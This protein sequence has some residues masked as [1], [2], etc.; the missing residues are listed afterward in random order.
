MNFKVGDEFLIV[1]PKGEKRYGL[2]GFVNTI[3]TITRIHQDTKRVYFMN[4]NWEWS[5]RVEHA[6]KPTKLHRAMK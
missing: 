2:D 3:Q 5:V 1:I 6:H 4:N